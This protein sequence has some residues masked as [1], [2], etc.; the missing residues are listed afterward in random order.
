MTIRALTYNAFSLLGRNRKRTLLTVLGIV[1]GV[2]SVIVILSVG[3]SAQRL[4]LSQVTSVGSNLVAI[5]PGYS[6][7]NG[8]PAS[9]F[10]VTVT[11]LTQDDA[12][13]LNTIA[14]IEAATGYVRG[15]G[16]IQWANQ[17][18]DTTF[19]GTTSDYL[20]VE[21][22]EL[23]YGNF[24]DESDNRGLARV[25]V[26]GYGPYQEL[27]GNENP[28][29]QRVKIKRESFRVIG[30]LDERG[31]VAFQNQ[32]DQVFIPLQTAQKIML[33]INHVSFIRAKVTNEQDIPIAIAQA[34]SILR[35]RH[36]ISEN[37][38]N[39]FSIRSSAQALE[40]LTTITGAL[41]F[42]L[43]GIAAISLLVGGIGIM[44]IM[45]VSVRERTKEIGLRKA[46]GATKNMI[47]LQFLT[48]SV[49][50]TMIG[51]LIGMLFGSLIALMVAIGA[52]AL[53]YEWSFVIAGD[54]MVLGV[55]VSAIVGIL[56]GWYPAR[57]AAELEPVEAL[58]Y[59]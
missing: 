39:D 33:G 14:E 50:V 5:L 22:P 47:Q 8:P 49:V 38:E 59:E 44:N 43:G 36:N 30:V 16:T 9:V 11:T 57:K 46:I 19:V 55:T 53:G 2:A 58:R 31:V 6:D 4:I 40:A 48:E 3:A 56:F 18:T 41:K 24:Y 52:H 34:E 37:Y 21:S 10:G 15:V 12:D 35:D 1:I 26:L 25:V 54:A 51:G 29:G 20:N 28:I 42:F 27:F 17:S 23:L 7:E 45:L 32:D 13:A